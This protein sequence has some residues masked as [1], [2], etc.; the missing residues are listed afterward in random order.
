[1]IVTSRIAVCLLCAVT[2]ALLLAFNSYNF[3]IFMTGY[4]LLLIL[5]LLH[6]H[7]HT[8]TYHP[9][10]FRIVG[11]LTPF[12]L[13][14]I[15]WLSVT[16]IIPEYMA[17]IILILA[18]TPL[19]TLNIMKL[20]CIMGLHYSFLV[21]LFGIL[22]YVTSLIIYGLSLPNIRIFKSLMVCSILYSMT[23]MLTDMKLIKGK[24][25]HVVNISESKCSSDDGPGLSRGPSSKLSHDMSTDIGLATT[26]YNAALGH[27]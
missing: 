8:V 2:S 11:I 12:L 26:N 22:I 6:F 9:Q 25:V 23:M 3:G 19:I 20:Y 17:S 21:A 10:A 24:R 5:N 16:R 15:A 4:T 7:D 18:S 14:P 1:M 13:I 27:V